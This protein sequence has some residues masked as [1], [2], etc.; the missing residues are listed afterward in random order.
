MSAI[1]SSPYLFLYV[2]FFPSKKRNDNIAIITIIVTINRIRREYLPGIT[3]KAREIIL[4]KMV[5][6]Q[7]NNTLCGCDNPERR[8]MW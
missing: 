4:N 3:I 2:I 5:I 8:R 1:L 7:R 6:N